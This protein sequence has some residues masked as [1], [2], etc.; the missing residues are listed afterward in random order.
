VNKDCFV[1]KKNATSYDY[2][3]RIK[4]GNVMSALIQVDNHDKEIGQIFKALFKAN[5]IGIQLELRG[6][7]GH[8]THSTAL[9]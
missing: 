9:N 4:H 1:N 8:L 6:S 7:A 3:Q 5:C 2:S